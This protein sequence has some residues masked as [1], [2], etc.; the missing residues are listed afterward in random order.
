[1]KTQARSVQSK[2]TSPQDTSPKLTTISNMTTIA[3]PAQNKSKCRMKTCF[4]KPYQVQR[5]PHLYSPEMKVHARL[6]TSRGKKPLGQPRK[7]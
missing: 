4:S 3:T 7:S 6:G 2:N 1:M 5:T